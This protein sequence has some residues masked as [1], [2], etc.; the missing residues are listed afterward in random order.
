MSPVSVMYS[1]AERNHLFTQSV[2]TR[3]LSPQP[4]YYSEVCITPHSEC[5]SGAPDDNLV[6]IP[7][8]YYQQRL[9]MKLVYF[10]GKQAFAILK[11]LFLICQPGDRHSSCLGHEIQDVR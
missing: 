9:K 7:Q 4:N 1:S 8:N 3:I 2:R 10:G 6:K 5:Q 11:Y